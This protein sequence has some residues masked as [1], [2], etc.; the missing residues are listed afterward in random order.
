MF[1]SSFSLYDKPFKK[2]L[3][4]SG[5]ISIIFNKLT[6]DFYISIIPFVF[7]SNSFSFLYLKIFL[8]Y[9]RILGVG[10]FDYTIVSLENHILSFYHFFIFFSFNFFQFTLFYCV[11]CCVYFSLDYFSTIMSNKKYENMYE[12]LKKK[13]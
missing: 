13:N 6:I 12:K 10:I 4:Y 9:L 3:Y 5:L 8:I 1:F 7:L 2:I 11:V